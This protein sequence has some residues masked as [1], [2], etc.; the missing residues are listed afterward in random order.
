MRKSRVRG[1]GGWEVAVVVGGNRDVAALGMIGC[2]CRVEAGIARV[3]GT[4][5]GGSMTGVEDIVGAEGM[6]EAGRR[7]LRIAVRLE[8]GGRRSL[9]RVASP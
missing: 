9:L 6:A 4:A 3:V 5:G 8:L 7:A 2:G 1:I